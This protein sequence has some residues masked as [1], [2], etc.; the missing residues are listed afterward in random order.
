VQETSIN[1]F[2]MKRKGE[3]P[4][5]EPFNFYENA[6]AVEMRRWRESC[7]KFSFDED[8]H[9]TQIPF[10]SRLTESHLLLHLHNFSRFACPR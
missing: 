1:I 10:H 5:G 6:G 2:K 3:A 9:D 8:W 4:R 7:L